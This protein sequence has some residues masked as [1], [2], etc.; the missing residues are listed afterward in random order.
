MRYFLQAFQRSDVV[1]RVDG[2]RQTAVQT[3]DLAVNERSQREEVEQIG[4][5]VPDLKK[6]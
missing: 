2:R 5:V 6:S 3:E 4:E 1:Q